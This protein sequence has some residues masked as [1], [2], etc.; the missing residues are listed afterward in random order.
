MGEN[1]SIEGSPKRYDLFEI[2]STRSNKQVYLL[3][4]TV[5]YEGFWDFWS[6]FQPKARQSWCYLF[7]NSAYDELRAE[8]P[9]LITIEEGEAGETLYF[10][11][12]DQP[13]LFSKACMLIE[14]Q[15]YLHQLLHFWHQRISAIYPNGECNLLTCYSSPLLGSF[16]PSLSPKEQADFI[17]IDNRI[18]LPWCLLLSEAQRVANSAEKATGFSLLTGAQNNGDGTDESSFSIDSPYRLSDSQY[19]LLTRSQRRHR[20][21]NDIFLRLSQYF[22][23]ELNIDQLNWLFCNSIEV[24]KEIS[25][26]ESECSFETFAVYRFVLEHDY[27]EKEAFKALMLKHDL[28]TSIQMFN[29]LNPPIYDE[30]FRAKQ[31]LW[32]TGVEQGRG[33][34]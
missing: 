3:V 11:L 34:A 12:L 19:E 29:Q 15:L 4:D 16:W 25:P 10:W 2:L 9:L 27:F 28:R 18:Y 22:V 8:S 33:P 5:F 6:S 32:L 21:V 26:G 13:Q 20:M 14:S 24:A 31:A 23:F 30:I 17:G 7:Q 1:S